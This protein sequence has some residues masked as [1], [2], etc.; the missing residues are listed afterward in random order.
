MPKGTSCCDT[1]CF[2]GSPECQGKKKNPESD[3][4]CTGQILLVLG[5]LC[6]NYHHFLL[7]W[8]SLCPS[9]RGA[10]WGLKGFGL[11]DVGFGAHSSSPPHC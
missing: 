10:E 2:T 5:R 11:G 1:G 9:A 6:V 3:L 8:A 4:S 7:T